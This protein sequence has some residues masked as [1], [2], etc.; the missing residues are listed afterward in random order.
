MKTI[1]YLFAAIGIADITL[2]VITGGEFM[3]I[4]GLL[5]ILVNK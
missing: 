3:F 2:R 5:S 1:Y 4:R